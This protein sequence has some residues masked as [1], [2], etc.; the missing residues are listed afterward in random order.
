MA[1]A[2]SRCSVRVGIYARISSDRDGDEL[3]VRRQEV[4]CERLATLKGWHI[5]DRYVD[6]DIS[7]WGGRRRPQYERMLADIE[8]GVLDGVVVYHLDRLHRHP[9]ELEEFFDVCKAAGVTDLATVTGRIDLA[10]PDG[11][12][13]ARILGAVARKESDDKSR[14]IRRKH[15]ELA[16]QGKVS[17]GGQPSFRLRGR[18][19]D[20]AAERGGDRARVR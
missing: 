4:D 7:A 2:V 12:F 20:A 9:K 17:G 11:Q 3:G 19:G 10:D 15:E 16:E 1:V 14:R 13:Q 6:D 18:Q 5:A 8:A